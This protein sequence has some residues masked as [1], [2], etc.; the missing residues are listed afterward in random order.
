MFVHG[1]LAV[2][3]ESKR[4]LR[5]QAVALRLGFLRVQR[6]R[7][8]GGRVHEDSSMPVKNQSNDARMAAL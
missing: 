7:F 1:A 3:A 6:G 5:A 2:H 8:R 4:K